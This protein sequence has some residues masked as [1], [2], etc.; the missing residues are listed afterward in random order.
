MILR[1]VVVTDETQTGIDPDQPVSS[2][3]KFSNVNRLNVDA[4]GPTWTVFIH[5]KKYLSRF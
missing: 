1:T 5:A 3:G 2:E 4:G